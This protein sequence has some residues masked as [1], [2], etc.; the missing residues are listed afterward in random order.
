MLTI[1]KDCTR[2]PPRVFIKV[3]ARVIPVFHR[4]Y[5]T[6]PLFNQA[7][8]KLTSSPGL[9]SYLDYTEKVLDLK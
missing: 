3:R 1:L 8:I 2:Y 6:S 7:V 5:E 9:Q 4:A